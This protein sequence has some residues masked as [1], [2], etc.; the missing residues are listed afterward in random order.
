MYVSIK[1]IKMLAEICP[2]YNMA[3]VGSKKRMGFC[4]I[5]VMIISKYTF[6]EFLNNTY[7]LTANY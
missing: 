5:H 2:I 4:C 3:A 6:E 7:P 1:A